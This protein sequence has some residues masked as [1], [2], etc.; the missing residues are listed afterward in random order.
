M[1]P[2]S[3]FQQLAEDFIARDCG[4]AE[5]G[6]ALAKAV[7]SQGSDRVLIDGIRHP[8]TLEALK[9]NLSIPVALLYVYTPPD[10]A[11]EMYRFREGHNEEAITF[12]QFVRLYTAPVKSRTPYLL[13][14]AD[15]ITFNWLGVEG[16]GMSSKA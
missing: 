15:I 9:S 7:Q 13:G 11:Y 16:Y 12:E 8:P 3:E 6:A 1:T 4:P 2:R 5:L 14:E 10:V